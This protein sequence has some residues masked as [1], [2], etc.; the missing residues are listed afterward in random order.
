MVRLWGHPSSPLLHCPQ[1][2][3]SFLEG[4]ELRAPGGG[5]K[6]PRMPL[7]SRAGGRHK[8]CPQRKVLESLWEEASLYRRVRL[9]ILHSALS[10]HRPLSWLRGGGNL[11]PWLLS[12]MAPGQVGAEHRL[13]RSKRGLPK[14]PLGT[15]VILST[16]WSLGRKIDRRTQKSS[17]QEP[18]SSV[19]SRRSC[20]PWQ[21]LP[22]GVS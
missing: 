12:D 4:P 2:P 14:V 18:Q 15:S 5:Y 9:E 3:R 20:G 11:G 1:G 8:L 13:S 10:T 6:G 22:A 17:L 21:T 19:Q 7:P 16:I